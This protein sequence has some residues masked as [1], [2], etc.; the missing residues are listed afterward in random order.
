MITTNLLSLQLEGVLFPHPFSIWH[1]G[2][3]LQVST[4]LAGPINLC[5]AN[6]EILCR[7]LC[8]HAAIELEIDTGSGRATITD[9]LGSIHSASIG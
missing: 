9:R 1:I 4:L 8:L 2:G 3:I 5:I 6:L 7:Y